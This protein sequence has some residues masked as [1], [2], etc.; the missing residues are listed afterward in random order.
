MR[1]G[2]IRDRLDTKT[3]HVVVVISNETFNMMTGRVLVAPFNATDQVMP[4]IPAQEGFVAFQ[5]LHS[6][7][8]IALSGPHGM[9]EQAVLAEAQAIL[10][11]AFTQ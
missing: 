2:E 5:A 9:V 11:G 7:P 3:T 4:G 10:A 6:L 8:H 1:P